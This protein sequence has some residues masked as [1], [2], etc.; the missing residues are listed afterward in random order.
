MVYAGRLVGGGGGG[1]ANTGSGDMPGN[2]ASSVYGSGDHPAVSHLAT[3]DMLV[4][5]ASAA[6]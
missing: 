6:A 5:Q 3:V 2:D 1:A 4:Q